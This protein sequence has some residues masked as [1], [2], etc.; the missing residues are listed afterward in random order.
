MKN[1]TCCFTGHRPEKLFLPEEQIKTLLEAAIRKAVSEGFCRFITGMAEGIDIWA[2][3]EVLKIKEKSKNIE[4]ICAIPY[5]GFGKG[6]AGKEKIQ[7]EEILAKADEIEYVCRHYSRQCFQMRNAYMV[8]NS[9]R[10]IAVFNGEK[11]GTKN[12]IQYAKSKG[13]E[14]INISQE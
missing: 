10:V 13:V 7:Y 6:R 3:E 1:V 5:D 4:L 12:T 11:G 2:A 9:S 8:D 14:V